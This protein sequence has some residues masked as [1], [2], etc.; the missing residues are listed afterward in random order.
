[1]VQ[2]EVF[3]VFTDPS[4]DKLPADRKSLAFS[5]TF[6][7]PERTLTSEEVSGSFERLKIALKS[8]LPV[9]FRE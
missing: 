6:R 5:L 3:D 1:L 7:A 4:G 8:A 9:E 2:V